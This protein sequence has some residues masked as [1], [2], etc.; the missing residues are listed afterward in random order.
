VRA[1]VRWVRASGAP[2][3]AL[4]GYSFGALMALRA[5]ADGEPADAFAAFGFPTTIVGDDPDRIADVRR[6][7]AGP[8]PSLFVSGDADQ[9]CEL[10]RLRGWAHESPTAR[11]DVL[12]G[13]GHFPSGPDAER[14]CRR[15]ADF[16]SAVLLADPRS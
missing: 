7:I 16:V 1:V 6:A 10:D 13:V 9:F 12:A 2:R 3:L 14:I 15:I 5:I 4:V 11:L 8:I